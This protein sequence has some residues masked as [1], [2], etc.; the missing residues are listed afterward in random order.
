MDARDFHRSTDATG[1]RH[2]Q[3]HNIPIGSTQRGMQLETH[4]KASI[5]FTQQ[6]HR[7]NSN[8][9]KQMG[10]PTRTLRFRNAAASE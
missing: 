10:L 9:G 7:A 6:T 5:D 8:A 1:G 4:L 3:Q 2:R